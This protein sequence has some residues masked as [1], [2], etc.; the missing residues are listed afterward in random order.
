MTPH[1]GNTIFSSVPPD[2]L[3]MTISGSSHTSLNATARKAHNLFVSQQKREVR[4]S[5]SQLK[6]QH[7]QLANSASVDSGTGSGGDNGFQGKDWK[8]MI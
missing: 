2:P 6:R 1:R 7:F 4:N 8:L 5:L 3:L